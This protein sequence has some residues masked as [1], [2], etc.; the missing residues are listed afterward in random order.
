MDGSNAATLESAAALNLAQTSMLKQGIAMEQQAVALVSQS[1][2]NTQAV[3][4]AAIQSAPGPGKGLVIDL[5]A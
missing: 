1:L 5:S 2:A 4:T 3:T